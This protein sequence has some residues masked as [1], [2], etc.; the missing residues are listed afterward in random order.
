[1]GF[2]EEMDDIAYDA[3]G[4]EIH[5]GDIVIWTDP[6]EGRK[7]EYEVFGEPTSDMVQ[8]WNKHGEC[9]ALPK[10]CVIIKSV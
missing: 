7:I 10:E 4:K 2:I 1:M 3:K 6:D 8:L 9:E 5:C